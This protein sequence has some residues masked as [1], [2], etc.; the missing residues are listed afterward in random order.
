MSRKRAWQ[1]PEQK[2][3]KKED[4]ARKKMERDVLRRRA[5]RLAEDNAAQQLAEAEQQ[6]RERHRE[7]TAQQLA[8]AREQ[9]RER[10]REQ[11]RQTRSI[12]VQDALEANYENAT[13]WDRRIL[14][15]ETV[16]NEE[17]VDDS[18][19]NND[20]S[21]DSD[22]SLRDDNDCYDSSSDNNTTSSDNDSS[23][24]NE[25]G[26]RDNS[27]LS[28]NANDPL[29]PALKEI[30]TEIGDGNFEH[31]NTPIHCHKDIQVAS[32]AFLDHVYKMNYFHCGFCHERG[33]HVK[34]KGNTL[35]CRVCF[36]SRTKEHSGVRH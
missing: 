21:S 34:Q 12:L 24:G 36:T 20:S 6:Y 26:I 31:A 9:Y 14:S 15:V 3:Q 30:L 8:E 19:S 33:P 25:G 22:D 5:K 1:T 32:K 2:A 28:T 27:Y 10:N 35:E 18:T 29:R 11:K 16:S 23:S 4:S 17:D 7:Q 13:E